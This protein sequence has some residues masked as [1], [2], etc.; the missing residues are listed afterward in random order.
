VT[1]SV[2]FVV[3]KAPVTWAELAF[4]CYRAAVAL[5]AGARAADAF[6]QV[7][8]LIEPALKAAD[9]D[10]DH[11]VAAIGGWSCGDGPC[12]YL[13]VHLAHP[14]RVADMFAGIPDTKLER[15]GEGHYRLD[16]PGV[17]GRRTIEVR[18]LPIHWAA[19]APAD[20]WSRDMAVATHVIFLSGVLYGGRDVDPMTVL[21]PPE[22]AAARVHELEGVL[23]DAHGRCV[24]GAVATRPFQPG[25]AL[26]HA[27]FGVAAPAGSGDALTHLLGSAR[28]LDLEVELTLAPAPTEPVVD[29][30]L[31]QGRAMVSVAMAPIKDQ[32]G[33]SGL[34]KAYV[35]MFEVVGSRGFASHLD[36]AALRLSWRTDRIHESDVTEIERELQG[37]LGNP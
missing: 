23:A 26:D 21:A 24:L 36:G 15:V 4:P 28:S 32:F 5:Q 20:P 12:L 1:S 27:R 34:T 6:T 17:R 35:E 8:P 22:A 3:P 25:F 10:I 30:W 33:A 16:A 31:D 19:A 7:S 2:T 9:I 18:V 37:A 11:D 29:G 13:A 14:E